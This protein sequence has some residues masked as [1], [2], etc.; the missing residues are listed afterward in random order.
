MGRPG[1]SASATSTPLARPSGSALPNSCLLNSSPS[2]F[3][4]PARVT[5]RPPETE[6]ISAGMTVTRPSPIVRTVYVSS[7][8]RKSMPCC[9][10]PIRKPARM[11]MPGDQDARHRIALREP[12][13]AV[14]RS[15]ELGF[16]RK[17]FAAR[18][19][20][21]F[22]DQAGVQV[23]VDR[24]LLSGQRIQRESRRDFRDADRAMVDD[25][26][27]NRDQHQEDDDTDDVVAADDEVAE[28]LD[29]VA[30]S[31]DVPELPF[32]RINRDEEMFS[33]SRNSVSSSRV[34]GKVLNSTGFV[35]Y[36]ETIRTTTDSMM[37]AAIS[38]SRRNAGNGVIIAITIASTPTGTAISP[39]C[40]QRHDY[41]GICRAAAT[42]FD[43][44]IP[45]P[46]ISTLLRPIR[47]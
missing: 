46:V 43:I 40:L 7:A 24:H 10:T 9:S 15:V 34:V 33:A 39:E 13:R 44:A 37:S 14:H 12:R 27:L 20:L 29:H 47:R 21:C 31:A 26:I 25:D 16:G 8:R 11:L 4:E 5:I 17:L 23:R 41:G 1:N 36:I 3:S 30:G 6:I 19:G 45:S 2:R 32:S 38:R 22:V 42:L 28:G 35:M 18:A